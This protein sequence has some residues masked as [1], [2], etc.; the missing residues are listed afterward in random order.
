MGEAGTRVKDQTNRSD[1]KVV[2]RIPTVVFICKSPINTIVPQPPPFQYFAYQLFL[3]SPRSFSVVPTE[4]KDN[5]Y[6]KFVEGNL[7]YG[8]CAN[9][10]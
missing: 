5:A 7:Y 10:E 9:G 8:T 4:I 1:N 6:A 3:T 2:T